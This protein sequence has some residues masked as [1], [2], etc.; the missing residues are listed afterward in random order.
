M[1]KLM[2]RYSKWLMVGFMCLLMLTWTVGPATQRIGEA[3]MGRVVGKLDGQKITLK[4]ELLAGK[5]L[6]ALQSVAGA[7]FVQGYLGVE[8]R[9][10][11]HWML[12]SREAEAAGLVGET[13]DGKSFI[14]QLMS[15]MVQSELQ[16]NFQLM[17]QIY[18]SQNPEQERQKIVDAMVKNVPRYYQAHGL[19]PDE[20]DRLMA[21]AH[22]VVRLIGSYRQA[23]RLSDRRA[24]AE[25]KIDLDAAVADYLFLPASLTSDKVP[26]P[27]DAA[28]A[29]HFD[30]FKTVKEGEGEHGIGYLLPRRVKLEWMKVDRAAIEAAIAVDPVELRKRYQQNHPA[31]YPG[32]FTAERANVEKDMKSEAADRAMQEAHLVVQAEVLKATRKLNN[33]GATKYKVLPPEWEQQRPR[34]EAIA[35]AVADAMK[36]AGITIPLPEVTV[37]ANEWVTERKIQSLPGL[38]LA[39]AR[40]GGLTLSFAQIVGWTR[41]F[42]GTEI[43][44]FPVQVGMPLVENFL[45]DSQGNR[46][47]VTILATRA[48]S[49]PDS[50]AE[51]KQD[52]IK[53]YKLLKAYDGLKSRIAELKDKAA[54]DG[55][56][57]VAA[58]FTPAAPV[59][60]PGVDPKTVE[61][62][63]PPEVHKASRITRTNAPDP[64]INQEPI[65]N[66][67]VDAAA[68]FDP[69]TPWGQLDAQK[70][71]V[72]VDAPKSLGIAV[73][74]IQAYSPLTREAYRTSDGQIV[75]RTQSE[76]LSPP[77]KTEKVQSPFSLEN[78]IKR[79][80][81][82]LNNQNIH[83]VDQLKKSEKVEG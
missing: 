66:A 3:Q 78:L 2:R 17:M 71:T 52:A 8:E 51:I 18:Q 77:S 33:D 1:T 36:K 45:T 79:H 58:M 23:N 35:Q 7:V 60:A 59:P 4:Q 41:E 9:D 42:G 63:K 65:R 21:K 68:T 74:R 40:Q 76:E 72:A 53:N 80:D 81:F 46:Y 49:A 15:A 11:T 44:P 43:G 38:G 61:A 34:F 30:Q 54:K 28:L 20:G 62:P 57:A 73:F 29:A 32:E 6:E 47:Y 25:A 10:S 27:D 22:G 37:N 70:A 56:E 14:P 5:E 13:E 55:L 31:K 69:M 82:V 19:T 16:R 75:S 83:S 26:D 39:S 64:Q 12:L 50:V 67:V 24:V 48:E